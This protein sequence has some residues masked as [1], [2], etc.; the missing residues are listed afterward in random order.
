[1]VAGS[2]TAA[3]ITAKKAP[4]AGV[5]PLFADLA[6]IRTQLRPRGKRKAPLDLELHVN[7][8][9]I[10]LTALGGAL[11]L[12]LLQLRVGAEDAQFGHWIWPRDGT[13]ASGEML[14]DAKGK[15]PKRVIGWLKDA[16]PIIGTHAMYETAVWYDTEMKSTYGLKPRQGFLGNGVG[17]SVEDYFIKSL[18]LPFWRR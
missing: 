7:P 14:A 13:E 3:A 9:A 17:T 16:D 4:E 6:V 2:A 11:A 1:M 5:K 15:A 10:G 8:V 12:W 18:Y